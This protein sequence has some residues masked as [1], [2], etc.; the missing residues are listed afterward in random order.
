MNSAK[1]ILF[2]S[3]LASLTAFACSSSDTTTE[4][5]PP[6]S[7]ESAEAPSAE[8]TLAA[9]VA[10]CE[11]CAEE[12]ATRHAE[13]AL[14]LRL[15][16]N[17]GIQRFVTTLIELHLQNDVVRPYMDGVD[18]DRLNRNLVDFIGAGTGGAETYTGRS[19]LDSH[20]GMGV[21]PEAFLAAGGDI[22]AAME[23]VGWGPDEQQEFLCII[24][25]MKDLVLESPGEDGQ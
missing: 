2:A 14:Y 20:A 4:A 23:A 17:E 21:T 15:G 13:R 19:V 8:E 1:P 18:L 3:L 24:L 25:S 12:R 5:S 22:G 11:A 7:V 9:M 16:G 6:L 10:D